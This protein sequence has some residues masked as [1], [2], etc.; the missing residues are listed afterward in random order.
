MI[1]TGFVAAKYSMGELLRKPY[2][3]LATLFRMIVLP[4]VFLSVLVVLKVEPLIIKMCLFA[5]ATALG[6]NT[7]VFPTEHVVGAYRNVEYIGSEVEVYT[8]GETGCAYYADDGSCLDEV[9][10][11]NCIGA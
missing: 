7:V 3:Y 5:T 6:L 8:C 10:F 1:L 2:V 11:G 4:T 9:S